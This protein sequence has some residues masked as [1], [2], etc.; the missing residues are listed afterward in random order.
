VQ[1][2][3]H[4]GLRDGD[5]N[6][7]DRWLLLAERI[8]TAAERVDVVLLCEVVDWHQY[9]HKQLVRAMRDL[10]PPMG[11][12]YRSEPPSPNSLR[13]S[14]CNVVSHVS[15]DSLA[16]QNSPRPPWVDRHW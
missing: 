4:G 2:L 13:A 8:N 3:G 12:L 6:P 7:E 16:S 9:G 14:T 1:N 15:T 11:P 10:G 5:G